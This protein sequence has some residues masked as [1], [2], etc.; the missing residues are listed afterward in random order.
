MLSCVFLE[1]DGISEERYK[2]LSREDSAV[3]VCCLCRGERQER[4]DKHHKKYKAN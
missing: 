2:E 1:C 4:V 3:Y